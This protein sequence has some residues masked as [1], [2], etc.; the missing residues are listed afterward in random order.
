MKQAR[1]QDIV[2][3]MPNILKNFGGYIKD[4]VDT[5]G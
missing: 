4:S 3:V 2:K 5:N 1:V